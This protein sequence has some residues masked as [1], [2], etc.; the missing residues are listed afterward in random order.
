MRSFW[1]RCE[2]NSGIEDAELNM[3]STHSNLHVHV[4]FSTKD[5]FPFMDRASRP[6][7]HAYIGGVARNLGATPLAI[8]GIEDHA[9]ALLGIKTSH[10]LD[11]LIRDIKGDSSTFAKKE[12]AKK[13]A[14]QKGYG[15]F[16]VSPSGIEDVRKYILDQEAH[17]ARRSFQEE[18][19]ELL[20]KTGTPFDEKYLW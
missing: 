11:Y 7:L 2:T 17:H 6:R 18:Y 15:V 10:R 5:R 20:E 14:W 9:H 16:S 13:F 19:L 1:K 3:P 12:F 4:V 8:G